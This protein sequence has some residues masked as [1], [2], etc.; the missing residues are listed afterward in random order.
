MSVSAERIEWRQA[1]SEEVNHYYR[2][3]F[4]SKIEAMPE[5]IVPPKPIEYAVALDKRYPVI[6]SS[7][8]ENNMNR[9]REFIRRSTRS[10][11]GKEIISDWNDLIDVLAS[12][13]HNDPQRTHGSSKRGALIDPDTASPEQFGDGNVASPPVAQ[14]A[15]Y[16]LDN[17]ERSWVLMFDIDAK[18]VAKVAHENMGREFTGGD[19][20]NDSQI[21]NDHPEGYPYRYEHIEATIE[22]AFTLKEWLED[23]LDFEETQVVYSGQGTHVYGLD[24][25]PY[26][27]YDQKSRRRIVSGVTSNLNIPI[28]E[29]VTTDE[30]R[31][32]RIP[33]SLHSNVCRVVT[34]ISSRDFDFRTN[35]LPNFVK[36][37]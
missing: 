32:A 21:V 5:W 26:Y 20:P 6:Q 16:S 34:P 29:Q 12:P 23:E 37:G 22:Y 11:Q 30:R 17:H 9:T 35:G 25:G 33:H 15:Y 4:P 7:N 27:R 1:T 14:A 8:R 28:D 18:D 24:S 19:L 3:E 36:P 31:V 13:A 10:K 2:E